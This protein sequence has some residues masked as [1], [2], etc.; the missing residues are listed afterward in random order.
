MEAVTPVIQSPTS[1]VF[2]DSCVV[3]CQTIFE[4]PWTQ[5][6]VEKQTMGD[7]FYYW[8]TR[9]ANITQSTKAVDCDYPCNPTCTA[10]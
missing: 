6:M 4:E 9:N 5:I 3:H 1:G 2:I 8:L 7:T 10:F